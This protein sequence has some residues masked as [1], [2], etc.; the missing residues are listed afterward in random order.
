MTK[1]NFALGEV[2]EISSHHMHVQYQVKTL[3]WQKSAITLL[4]D[5]VLQQLMG[6]LLQVISFVIL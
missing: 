2:A 1:S 5:A 6:L 3:I 4:H